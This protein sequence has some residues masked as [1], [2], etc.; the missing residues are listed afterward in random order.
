MFKKFVS[1]FLCIVTVFTFT[2]A[3]FIS[4]G[5][6]TAEAASSFTLPYY[7]YQMSDEAQDFYLYLRKAVKECRTKLKLNVDFEIE[8]FGMMVELLIYHDPMTF[9]LEDM[10]VLDETKNSV[11]FG[12][13]YKYDKETYDKM[14][15]AYDKAANKILSKFTDGMS[16]YNKIKT[17]HDEIIKNTMYDLESADNSNIYGALVDNKAKCDGYA[18]T[19][20]YVCGKA[21]IRTVTV[22]GNDLTADSDENGHMWNKVYYNKKW[23]NI[24]VTWDDP[25]NDMKDNIQYDYFMV[26][27]KALKN[28]HKEDNLSFKVPKADDDTRGYYV[29]NK[30]YAESN[31]D[32]EKLI[33]SGL[34]TAVQNGEKS[35]SFKFASKDIMNH[36]NDYLNDSDK[37]YRV[38][39]DVINSTGKKLAGMYYWSFDENLLTVRVYIF[40]NDTKLEDYFIDPDSIDSEDLETL[41][42]YGI[43]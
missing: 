5:G 7:Y 28:T 27:D 34:K 32:A 19:F 9:N 40:Y 37:M 21:G 4:S 11:T 1:V 35:F 43:T 26:S 8:E 14:V 12:F 20:S 22:I 38:F 24:D 17:I 29:V 13:E 30:K 6:I 25:V 33:K 16:T 15:K 10:N 18:K 3:A 36:V 31:Q 23:Y 42:K 41:E 2:S 39:K